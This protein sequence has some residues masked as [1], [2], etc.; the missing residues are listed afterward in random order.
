MKTKNLIKTLLTLIFISALSFH[1]FSLPTF[2]RSIPITTQESKEDKKDTQTTNSICDLDVPDEVKA[3]SGCKDAGEVG[4]LDETIVG[5]LNAIILAIG[6]VT[7]IFVIVGGINYMTSTGDP[8]KV[9]KAKDTI[10]YG[11]IGLIICAL[12][13]VIVN[14]VIA[15]ILNQSA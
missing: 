12:S 13:F 4:T 10:L 9:K 11:L 14:F 6:V 2:A 7:V 5:I 15:N 1:I 8:G 3:S